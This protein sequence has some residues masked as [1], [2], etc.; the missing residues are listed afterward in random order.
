MVAV[1]VRHQRSGR[2]GKL[3]DS[4]TREY[5]QVFRVLVTSSL[6]GPEVAGSALGI[7]RIWAPY[8]P[9]S[10]V[11]DLG[12]WCRSVEAKPLDSDY[13]WEVVC[14]YSSKLEKGDR[15]PDQQNEN[16][17]LRP[18]EVSFGTDRVARPFEYDR[19]GYPVQNSAGQPFDPPLMTDEKILTI[20]VSKNQTT[21]NQGYYTDFIDSVNSD[22]W[23]GFLRGQVKCVDIR[24]DLQWESSY[25]YWRVTYQFHAKK[26]RIPK[27]WR[28]AN[29]AEKKIFTRQKI[30]LSWCEFIL[31]RGW[32]EEY[33]DSEGAT[34]LRPIWSPDGTSTVSSP[35][36]LDGLGKA[37][38]RPVNERAKKSGDTGSGGAGGDWGDDELGEDYDPDEDP[39]SE[40]PTPTTPLPPDS[41]N[42]PPARDDGSSGVTQ[43]DPVFLAYCKFP[44]RKF[45]SLGL[46]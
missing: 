22:K 39:D 40:S 26:A 3:D 30:E 14:T 35:A 16:P 15:R 7:P 45:A 24:A 34:H 25:P 21:Y 12:S 2:T 13:V 31:D 43:D 32:M 29:P 37:I 27:K 23:M 44:F 1:L 17:T 36:L 18:P 20:R 41:G 42:S 11:M 6:D 46:F 28:F 33:E 9:P 4:R 10:G 19:L 5:V 38:L 8:I